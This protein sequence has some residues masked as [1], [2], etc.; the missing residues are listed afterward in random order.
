MTGTAK[1]IETRIEI[2]NANVVDGVANAG[3]CGLQNL[4][5]GEVCGRESGH[6]GPCS[7]VDPADV[8]GA[9]ATHGIDL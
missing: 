8:A 5:D 1:R 6:A 9:L 2:H 3:G 7:F 4:Q